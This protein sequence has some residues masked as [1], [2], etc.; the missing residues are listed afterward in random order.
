MSDQLVSGGTIVTIIIGLVIGYSY[1]RYM[2]GA[3]QRAVRTR[4]EADVGQDRYRF[5]LVGA[6][7][8]VLGSIGAITAYGFGPALLYVG[9]GLALASALAVSYCL[10]E[11]YVE[12]DPSR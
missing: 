8:A 7:I 6:I 11:E 4:D 12:K 10:R 1:L 9:P 3:L 2:W 5:S